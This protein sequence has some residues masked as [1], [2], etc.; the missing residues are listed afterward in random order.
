MN[1][2]ESDRIRALFL[3]ALEIAE[4]RRV[5]WLIAETG[6]D[7]SLL[8]E[9]HSL[10]RHVSP[11]HDPLEMPLGCAVP[12]IEEALTVRHFRGTPID[13]APL[14]PMKG[15]EFLSRLAD[16]GILS[17]EELAEVK[18]SM[19]GQ[20]YSGT[21]QVASDWIARHRLAQYQAG[22]L[23]RGQPEMLIDKYLILDLIDSGGMGIVFKALHR[24][25][26]RIV[27]IKMISK[28]RLA[29]DKQIQRFQREL[30]VAAKLEHPNVV[31]AYDAD[32]HDGTHFMVMEY[33]RGENLDHLV[34]RKGRISVEKAVDYIYQA[35]K[36]IEYAHQNGVI[37]RDIKPANFMLT[38]D[39]LVKV[40]DLGL[41]RIGD[42]SAEGSQQPLRASQP[43]DDSVKSGMTEA[44][45]LMGTVSYMPPE[46]S[47]DAAQVDGR[48]DIYSLGCTLYFLL[49]GEPPF[50]GQS[51]REILDAH[52]NA[53]IPSLQEQRSSVP[54]SVADI[55]ECCLSKEPKH[56][57][58]SVT[59]LIT[60]LENCGVALSPAPGK[61]PSS[62][63]VSADSESHGQL[64][65]LALSK[66]R[67]LSL[68]IGV[69]L[70]CAIS[71]FL[72]ILGFLPTWS[73]AVSP[74]D[75]QVG[76]TVMLLSDQSLFHEDVEL[77]SLYAGQRI[78]VQ[79]VEEGRLWTRLIA[80]QQVGEHGGA[81]RAAKFSRDGEYVVSCDEFGEAILWSPFDDAGSPVRFGVEESKN[82]LDIDYNSTGNR[83]TAVGLDGLVVWDATTLEQ[84]WR[85]VP[86]NLGYDVAYSPGG[87]LLAVAE[88]GYYPRD[89]TK[90]I[91]VPCN[92][93]IW[94]ADTGRLVNKLQGNARDVHAVAFSPDGLRIAS[95]GKDH[96][97]RIW[98]VA[99]G[100]PL[101]HW[102]T[103]DLVA[104]IL[105]LP[106]DD[107]IASTG[108]AGSVIVWNASSGKQ[109]KRFHFSGSKGYAIA[110]NQNSELIACADE[111]GVI[112][113]WSMN[114]Q[115]KAEF[116]A[117]QQMAQGLAFSPDGR[118][119]VT[120]SHDSKVKLWAIGD[121]QGIEGWI[122]TTSVVS[123]PDRG[124]PEA[125]SREL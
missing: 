100:E 25:M 106:E 73:S 110:Y 65:P 96:S 101:A 90:R 30:R 43:T 44:G 68:V 15:S 117:H 63:Q 60:A 22:A 78:V 62:R 13:D 56:R 7:L 20:D 61:R 105:Y 4:D 47:Q 33:V 93:S 39:G 115:K 24:P 52:G 69:L 2:G 59:E 35:A 87:R 57:F 45:S 89:P 14:E 113:I 31:R 51:S 23:L 50:R 38:A 6:G 102:S 84:L 8:Q 34:R 36:G 41:A 10:L 29:T 124:E 79:N 21:K 17:E 111:H 64:I 37:H 88:C 108:D 125:V 86:E 91:Y 71:A 107:L 94:N 121:G 1:E 58:Q 70:G 28:H 42:V 103:G 5:A 53:E 118:Q 54:L 122:P 85:A 40:L 123:V 80:F 95:G 18:R 119:L 92:V 19:H 49:I 109:I 67:D 97:I 74:G 16:V 12:D 76:Q 46:Q 98:D 66:Y 55:Y 116:Q 83:I 27:A 104:D 48:S 99:T 81:A 82:L 114:G 11:D 75:I 26:N 9:V 112:R 77:S 32:Q 72:M 120:S 3:R